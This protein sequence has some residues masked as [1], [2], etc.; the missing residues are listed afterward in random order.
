MSGFLSWVGEVISRLQFFI[1]TPEYERSVLLRFGRHVR[2]LGPGFHILIPVVHQAISVAIRPR[3][4]D[5]GQLSVERESDAVVLAV[6]GNVEY[7]MVD[8]GLSCLR[9]DEI[10]ESLEAAG[11]GIVAR[12]IVESDDAA[13][14]DDLT[15]FVHDRLQDHFRPWGVKVRQFWFTDLCSHKVFRL[16]QGQG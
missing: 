2:T 6:S 3:V 12:V 14:I 5:L 13:A 4:L 11:R 1:I 8:A 15:G 10:E 7:E 16:L 9:V